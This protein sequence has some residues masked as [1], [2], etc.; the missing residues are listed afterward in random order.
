MKKSYYLLMG[1][2]L[3]FLLSPVITAVIIEDNSQMHSPYRRDEQGTFQKLEVGLVEPEKHNSFL[4]HLLEISDDLEV[5]LFFRSL[6]PDSTGVPHHKRAIIIYYLIGNENRLDRLPFNNTPSSKSFNQAEFFYTSDKTA[7]Y[8]QGELCLVSGANPTYLGSL[9]N[10]QGSLSD[11]EMFLLDTTTDKTQQFLD[12]V[13]SKTGVTLTP[14]DLDDMNRFYRTDFLTTY[15]TAIKNGIRSPQILV[16]STSLAAMMLIYILHKRRL[17]IRILMGYKYRHLY[18]ELVKVMIVPTLFIALLSFVPYLL[19]HNIRLS[20]GAYPILLAYLPVLLLFLILQLLVCGVLLLDLRFHSPLQTLKREK[21]PAL[22][23]TMTVGLKVL[24]LILG[25]PLLTH[26]FSRL[27]GVLNFYQTKNDMMSRYNDV[28]YIQAEIPNTNLA[29]FD[30]QGQRMDNRFEGDNLSWFKAFYDMIRDDYPVVVSRVNKILSDG[31]YEVRANGNFVRMNGLRNLSGDLILSDN[32]TKQVLMSE[33]RQL[34]KDYLKTEPGQLDYYSTVTKAFAPDGNI[35]LHQIEAKEPEVLE[36]NSQIRTFFIEAMNP[37]YEQ[38]VDKFIIA[39]NS[40]IIPNNF[41]DMKFV[42]IDD[43]KRAELL[44]KVSE[45]PFSHHLKWISFDEYYS[46]VTSVYEEESHRA[47]LEIL[48]VVLAMVFY[49]LFLYMVLYEWLAQRISVAYLFGQP[50]WSS[51]KIILLA[52][53]AITVSL[54]AVMVRITPVFDTAQI[55]QVFLFCVALDGL[56]FLIS[57]FYYTRK[58]LRNLA[59]RE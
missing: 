40:D 54:I 9:M 37:D 31:A 32:E 25:I 26:Q 18:M 17:S 29:E 50:Y 20:Y 34:T 56:F 6:N 11:G 49:S 43:D 1:I 15:Y 39:V 35:P 44:D 23:L 21:N 55:W 48:S 41:D 28:W 52:N 59:V 12:E 5:N 47:L 45:L 22:I 19:V 53:L 24:V 3:Y 38:V 27:D 36:H 57:H 7:E 42:G 13:Q 16:I 8:S 51:A 4:N 10:Y 14:I 2:A 33:D 46:K 30:H 58:T